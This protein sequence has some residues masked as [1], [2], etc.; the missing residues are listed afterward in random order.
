MTAAG[1]SPF[2]QL[3]E[4]SLALINRALAAFRLEVDAA[5]GTGVVVA[6]PSR[7]WSGRARL[8]STRR[9]GVR[10]EDALVRFMSIA[11]EFTFG[12]LIHVTETKLP[13]DE[14]IRVLWARYEERHS[15]TW[16]QRFASWEA[17]HKVAVSSFPKYSPLW[18]YI[19]ARNAIVHGVGSLTR[20]QLAKRARSVG[21]LSTARIGV[22]GDR[23]ILA[24]GNAI[25]CA[26]VVRELIT[27]LDAQA[28][29]IT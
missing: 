3:S 23:V 10:T 22:S 21:R 7:I 25:E 2:F 8:S 24:P 28:A 18:G 17:L 9:R 1:P 16:E 15:N 26:V 11:D 6:L 29:S 19:E 12:L 5:S 27:W 4:T 20:R 13:K 14:R